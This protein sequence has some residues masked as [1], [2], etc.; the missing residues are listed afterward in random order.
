MP[1]V[2]L[3]SEDEERISRVDLAHV[4]SNH[5]PIE[6]IGSYAADRALRAGLRGKQPQLTNLANCSVI[7]YFALKRNPNDTVPFAATITSC[8]FSPRIGCQA[9]MR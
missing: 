1:I 6:C 9:L 8:T 2:F 5:V 4:G 7:T 3:Q